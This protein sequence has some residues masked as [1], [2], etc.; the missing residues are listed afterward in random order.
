MPGYEGQW[1]G[2]LAVFG[3]EQSLIFSRTHEQASHAVSAI[4]VAAMSCDHVGVRKSVSASD[5]IV[6]YGQF[7]NYLS[8]AL[9]VSHGRSSLVFFIR[10]VHDRIPS[11]CTRNYRHLVLDSSCIL[12]CHGVE[13]CTDS[14]VVR[15]ELNS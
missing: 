9:N 13:R 3:R 5:T 11:Y 1:Y 7:L 8:L 12:R 4:L 10:K 6:F 15:T 14:G 2:L